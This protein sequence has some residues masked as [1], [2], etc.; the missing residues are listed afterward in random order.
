M[1]IRDRSR[2]IHVVDDDTTAPGASFNE[3][4]SATQTDGSRTPFEW[5]YSPD[6]SSATLV[7]TRD[8]TEIFNGPAPASGTFAYGPALGVY[9]ATLTVTDNDNDRPGDSLSFSTSRSVTVVDDDTTAP[10]VAFDEP[11]LATLLDSAG[12]LLTWG[13]APDV[14]T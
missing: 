4:T 10:T 9:T 7:V 2:T 12:T 5:L 8:G 6:V 11:R 14:S 3:P 13:Y 1:C